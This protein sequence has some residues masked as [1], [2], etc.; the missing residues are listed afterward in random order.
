MMGVARLVVHI[1][2][3]TIMVVVVVMVGFIVTLLV[4]AVTMDVAGRVV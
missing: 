3:Y 2:V 4:R 1:P